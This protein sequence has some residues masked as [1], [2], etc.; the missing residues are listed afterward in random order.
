MYLVGGGEREERDK[1]RGPEE[2]VFEFRTQEHTRVRDEQGQRQH[3]QGEVEAHPEHFIDPFRVVRLGNDNL[4]KKRVSFLFFLRHFQAG[5]A[6]ATSST[7]RFLAQVP[8]GR[9]RQPSADRVGA[10]H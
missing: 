9:T 1:E 3:A 7:M 2:E 4:P 5:E 6:T 8:A 10:R